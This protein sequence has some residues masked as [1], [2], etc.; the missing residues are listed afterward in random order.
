MSNDRKTVVSLLVNFK[1]KPMKT[2]FTNGEWC[3]R[4]TNSSVIIETDETIIA[5]LHR[6]T[7]HDECDDNANLII[8][9]PEMFESLVGLLKTMPLGFSNEYTELAKSV[10]NKVMA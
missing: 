4:D 2:K 3:K 1:S 9:A 10:I 8:A 5:E 7:N 6:W